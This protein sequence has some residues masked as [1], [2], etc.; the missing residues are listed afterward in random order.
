MKLSSLKAHKKFLVGRFHEK[1]LAFRLTA[2]LSNQLY[3]QNGLCSRRMQVRYLLLNEHV[4]ICWYGST[5]TNKY[6]KTGV[7]ESKL[8]RYW[9]G[10]EGL[11]SYKPQPMTQQVLYYSEQNT[12]KTGFYLLRIFQSS[13]RTKGQIKMKQNSILLNLRCVIQFMFLFF[14]SLKFLAKFC[15]FFKHF[16]IFFTENKP[17]PNMSRIWESVRKVTIN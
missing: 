3:C 16:H 9:F 8:P 6:C 7:R 1:R 17:A 15:R 14:Q 13:R 5:L 4:Q 10:K 11:P 12:K 2:K